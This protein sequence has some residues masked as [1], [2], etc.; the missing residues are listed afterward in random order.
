MFKWLGSILDSNEREIKRLAPTVTHINR[1]EA[2]YQALSPEALRQ[3]TIE[4]KD[5]IKENTSELR[6]RLAEKRQE[7]EKAKPVI[8]EGLTP[9][10]KNGQFNQGKVFEEELNSLDKEL[11]NAEKRILNDILPEAF[12]A[13]REAAR[14]T[15]GQRHYD[16]QL[17]GG[18]ILH[19]GKIAEMRTGEGK[20]LVATLPLYLNSLTGRGVHLVTVNDYLARR[21][22]Y[23]MGPIFH[24]LG[25]R[26]ASI[27]PILTPDEMQPSRL[28]DPDFDSGDRTWPHFRKISRQEAYEA[29]IIY[30]QSS[31]FGF[32]Y[33]RDNMVVELT[34]M[35]QRP[36]NFAVVDEVD[37]LLIDE[38][39]TPLIISGQREESL[40]EYE[41]LARVAAQLKIDT[42]YKMS[43]KG[44]SVDEIQRKDSKRPGGFCNAK[45]FS[46]LVP[47]TTSKIPVSCTTCGTPSPPKKPTTGIRNTS[48]K[49]TK[50]SSLMSLPGVLCWDGVMKPGCTR[51]SK[52]RST[53]V[54]RK[55]P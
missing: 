36:L 21:D 13:V 18:I 54:F 10:E 25:V 6:S 8:V 23:W 43:E 50:L 17:I 24:A 30:G 2:E 32:D 41:V 42:D 26:V 14:R 7:I 45:G 28:F 9:L 5:R 12:A 19:Q 33:L 35:V 34:Q 29:D 27:Y 16:V 3:K 40:K 31:E 47:S 15:I 55:K 39:R 22:P 46:L 51:Q 38:A 52:P 49:T 11:A 1:L 53:S 37:N 4:F 44:R 20:T 48:L